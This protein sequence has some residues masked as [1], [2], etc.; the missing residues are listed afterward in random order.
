MT[1]I[2]KGTKKFALIGKFG[3]M[4]LLM[5]IMVVGIFFTLTL[6]VL[7]TKEREKIVRESVEDMKMILIKMAEFEAEVGMTAWDISQL[8]IRDFKSK[9]FKYS[10]TD[11][12]TAVTAIT[13][14]L[15]AEEKMFYFDLREKRFRVRQDSKNIIEDNWLP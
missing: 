12:D 10:I 13:N 6:S 1:N 11:P 14:S 7:Q 15:V 3:I 4:D 8:N 2:N 9:H 5:V